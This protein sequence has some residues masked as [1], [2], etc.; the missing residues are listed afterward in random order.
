MKLQ[1]YDYLQKKKDKVANFKLKV[2]NKA[3]KSV[4]EKLV[5]KLCG[6][7]LDE[8]EYDEEIFDLV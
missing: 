4:C 7:V 1:A 5:I 3:E 8:K 6:E 2:I